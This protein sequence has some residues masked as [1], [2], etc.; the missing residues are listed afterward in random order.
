LDLQAN[1][2]RAATPEAV[3]NQNTLLEKL[4]K[5]P[6]TN[7]ERAAQPDDI[8][9]D[10][11]IHGWVIRYRMTKHFKDLIRNLYMEAIETEDARDFTIGAQE[12]LKKEIESW[13]E[14]PMSAEEFMAHQE[15]QAEKVK[16]MATIKRLQDKWKE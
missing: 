13:G 9:Q 6:W 1:L 8:N 11:A 16:D 4:S 15:R 14:K 3:M 7:E 10:L 5:Q 2:Q 12:Q